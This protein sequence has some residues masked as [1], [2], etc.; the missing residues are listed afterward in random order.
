MPASRRSRAGRIS[1][2]GEFEEIK[3]EKE[4]ERMIYKKRVPQRLAESR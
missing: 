4:G 1:E 3:P 2:T